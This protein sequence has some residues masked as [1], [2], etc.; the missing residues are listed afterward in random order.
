MAKR[1]GAEAIVVGA[2]AFASTRAHGM[3][4]ATLFRRV[5]KGEQE[6]RLGSQSCHLFSGG[7]NSR[8]K[9]FGEIQKM[10]AFCAFLA[11]F[12]SHQ[13]NRYFTCADLLHQLGRIQVRTVIPAHLLDGNDGLTAILSHQKERSIH[14]AIFHEEAG[15]RGVS[16][17]KV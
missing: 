1:L 14:Q 10:D 5:E 4:V 9:I 12:H 13:R 3:F 2:T 8:I 15:S 6:W 11:C 17:S 16:G 7:L